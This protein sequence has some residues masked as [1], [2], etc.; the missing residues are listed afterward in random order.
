MTGQLF[1]NVDEVLFIENESDQDDA[2]YQPAG[3]KNIAKR[4]T[5]VLFD[6][7][8][9]DSPGQSRMEIFDPFKNKKDQELLSSIKAN[10]IIT[11]IYVRSL[12]NGKKK[13][14]KREYALVTGHRRV[15]AGRI[16]GLAGTDG[17]VIKDGEDHLIMTI[18]E[19]TGRRELSSY[20][21]GLSLQSF[22][23]ERGFTVRQIAEVT[24]LSKSYVGELIQALQSPDALAQIWAEG[25]IS[26][27]ALVLLKEHWTALAKEE[28][29]KLNTVLRG[30]SQ[31]QAG[32][33]AEHL[34][35]GRSL[36]QAAAVISGAGPEKTQV[37][38]ATPGTENNIV[39]SDEIIQDLVEVF[40]GI[41]EKQARV[42]FDYSAGLGTKDPEI[43]W[44]AA[45][46]VNR[47]GNLNHAVELSKKALAKRSHKALISRQIK[48]AIQA[49]SHLKITQKEDKT[50]R[51]FLKVV[52]S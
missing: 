14:G 15:A 48:L 31:Q 25:E 43:L 19:N 49:A 36:K 27:K 29:S 20:E 7:I 41:K 23:D 8:V 50:I 1:E 26:P 37:R 34:D 38:M 12:G 47:G 16:A 32:K 51:E 2:L 45:L 17:C 6:E 5:F 33:L 11:P 9:Q 30:L 42:L 13:R 52:L 46:Y 44:A 18:T 40:P 3:L 39:N 22:K 4:L 21:R 35:A 28:T 10:G 24:G